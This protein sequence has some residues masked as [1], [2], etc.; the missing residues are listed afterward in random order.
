MSVTHGLHHK[1]SSRHLRTTLDEVD[2]GTA[3]KLFDENG[4]FYSRNSNGPSCNLK[5]TMIQDSIIYPD[6]FSDRFEG[7]SK[8]FNTE[9]DK[10]RE[11]A[12]MNHSFNNLGAN[13]F[14]IETVP[15]DI[16][17]EPLNLEKEP[18][19]LQTESFHL[20][21]VPLNLQS[22]RHELTVASDMDISSET[23]LS[24]PIHSASSGT[25]QS[26]SPHLY[27][28]PTTMKPRV[29]S[30]V[31]CK[32]SKLEIRKPGLTS[33]LVPK[34]ATNEEKVLDSVLGSPGIRRVS[35]KISGQHFNQSYTHNHVIQKRR[36]CLALDRPKNKKIIRHIQS[37]LDL[38]DNSRMTHFPSVS[39]DSDKLSIKE[40]YIPSTSTP[41]LKPCKDSSLSSQEYKCRNNMCFG[42]H[43]PLPEDI[44]KSC[45]TNITAISGLPSSENNK[46]TFRYFCSQCI[47]LRDPMFDTF[48]QVLKIEMQASF[49]RP[50][51]TYYVFEEN[52]NGW[53]NALAKRFRWRWRLKGL[54]TDLRD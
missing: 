45:T 44:R 50:K 16:Q 21:K 46:K 34:Y 23:I 47:D 48:S 19:D 29:I 13:T 17:T 51:E 53:L 52:T 14:D 8:C 6:I 4:A 10:V 28:L 31:N 42:C 15:L 49:E 12:P 26:W 20:E 38:I 33:S 30:G 43:K 27:E 9:T 22:Q 36:S 37:K 32:E 39:I 54:L 25:P 41:T 5:Q 35:R 18:P 1:I 11:E 7:A 2:V 3:S 40:D 24:T